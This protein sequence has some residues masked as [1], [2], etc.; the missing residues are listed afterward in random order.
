M[1]F[2][3]QALQRPPQK[4]LHAQQLETLTN[5]IKQNSQLHALALG[6]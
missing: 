4:L 6:H 1:A 5:D 3:G 2:R